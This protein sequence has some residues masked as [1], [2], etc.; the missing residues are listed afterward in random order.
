MICEGHLHEVAGHVGPGERLVGHIRE[1]I[2][3]GVA[4]SWKRVWASS[5]VMSEGFSAVG[6]VKF[7]TL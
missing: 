6:L 7:P 3:E 1:Q 5:K 2:V 4:N